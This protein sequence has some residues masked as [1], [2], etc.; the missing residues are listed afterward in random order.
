M[1]K[2][3]IQAMRPLPRWSSQRTPLENGDKKT[4]IIASSILAS[5]LLIFTI[6]FL[7]SDR[8]PSISAIMPSIAVPGDEVR[9]KGR[10]LK[11][12]SEFDRIEFAGKQVTDSHI[13][14]WERNHIVMKVPHRISSGMVYVVTRLGKSNGI[15]FTNANHIPVKQSD[16]GLS[17]YHQPQIQS[18]VT[19]SGS[20]GS[21]VVLSGDRFGLRQFDSALILSDDQ[22]DLDLSQSYPLLIELWS[23]R[24]IRFRLPDIS[25][26]GQLIIRTAESESLALPCEILP[27]GGQLLA[28]K[29]VRHII[30]QQALFIAKSEEKKRVKGM[31]EFP[32]PGDALFQEVAEVSFSHKVK[33][34]D[35]TVNRV[36]FSIPASEQAVTVFQQ[37]SVTRQA[38]EHQLEDDFLKDDYD[39]ASAL[40]HYY[41]E[42]GGIEGEGSLLVKNVANALKRRAPDAIS[43]ARTNYKYVRDRLTPVAGYQDSL[44]ESVEAKQGSPWHYSA[45]FTAICRNQ[46]IPARMV[47]GLVFGG[48][49][50]FPHQW[51]E[52][53]IDHYGWIPV[54]PWL[55]DLADDEPDYP[56]REDRFSYYFGSLSSGHVQF[57][58]GRSAESMLPAPAMPSWRLAKDAQPLEL[59]LSRRSF[60]PECRGWLSTAGDQFDISFDV[61]KMSGQP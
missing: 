47:R 12:R 21:L 18:P 11:S 59:R 43:R 54:D 14:S 6:T 22:S 50:W 33:P 42:A 49:R 23:D 41:T 44:T 4:L 3:R 16:S 61:L 45:L 48:E 19:I 2:K 34:G 30:G 56:L 39:T 13:V 32:V 40:Y 57:D 29:P 38:L 28:G 15:L 17:G 8:A 53:Y 52:F 9:I 35:R 25:F 31:L 24:E 51:A 60:L 27:V 1:K 7:F 20:P 55:A 5:L 26:S 36:E 10:F 46:G 37:L 58:M